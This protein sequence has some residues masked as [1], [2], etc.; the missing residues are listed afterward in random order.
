[1]P[2][3]TVTA[4]TT[5]A[6]DDVCAL[7][8]DFARY[9]DRTDAVVEVLVHPGDADG[10]TVSE[11]TVRFRDG[12]LRW[13]ERDVVDPARRTIA[14]EQLTGDFA[15]FRGRWAMTPDAAGATVVFDA[16]FDLGIPSLSALIDPV[17][18]ATLRGTILQILSG[19]LDEEI[20][21]SDLPD[22]ARRT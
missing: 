18:T 19:T 1:M 8:S 11:W 21:P 14:S 10:G 15:V 4:R 22:H 17:A 7:I 9:Q 20:V 3:V 13:T 12:L 2:E 5:R 6:L 16:E